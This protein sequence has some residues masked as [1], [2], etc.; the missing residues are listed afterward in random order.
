MAL[1][2]INIQYQISNPIYQAIPWPD[3]VAF[4]MGVYCPGN[5]NY[6]RLIRRTVVR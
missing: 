4:Q 1:D 3:E 5:D 2:I 6:S